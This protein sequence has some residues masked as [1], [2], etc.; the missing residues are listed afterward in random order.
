[1]SCLSRAIVQPVSYLVTRKRVRARPG[2]SP[3]SIWICANFKY[4]DSD[5][6]L[7]LRIVK[8]KAAA[9]AAGRALLVARRLGSTATH[10]QH[11]C[12]RVRQRA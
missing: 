8:L 6:A 3:S 11:A 12:T 7:P 9:S 4:L 2:V 10:I 5:P 1:M